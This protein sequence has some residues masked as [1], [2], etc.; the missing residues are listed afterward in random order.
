[1][2]AQKVSNPMK[3]AFQDSFYPSPCLDSL[4][5]CDCDQVNLPDG[6]EIV[7]FKD[8]RL[9]YVLQIF[10]RE[11]TMP[12]GQSL[13]LVSNPE[14]HDLWDAK[15]ERFI[16]DELNLFVQSMRPTDEVI[17][18]YEGIAEITGNLD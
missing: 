2:D 11:G 13:P 7:M 10:W 18:T 4:T 14:L 12:L 6:T 3:A 9:G 8:V 15:K 17:F 16:P 1:M 5:G